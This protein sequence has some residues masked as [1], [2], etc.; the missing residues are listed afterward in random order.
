MG[1]LPG[2]VRP[3]TRS[4]QTQGGQPAHRPPLPTAPA[5]APY[6]KNPV[7]L[8]PQNK[9]VHVTEQGAERG[10]ERATRG[11]EVTGRVIQRS[12]RRR[13]ASLNTDRP[14]IHQ[15]RPRES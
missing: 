7:A 8:L 14:V 12:R 6:F 10:V 4:A 15:S 11:S 5:P 13:R 9:N 3:Q 1:P 2:R